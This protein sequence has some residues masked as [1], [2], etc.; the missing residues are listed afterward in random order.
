MKYPNK[1]YKYHGV[2]NHN[3]YCNVFANN[4]STLKRLASEHANAICYRVIDEMDVY[5]MKSSEKLCSMTRI[6]KKFPNN[7][8]IR[9][10]W[11]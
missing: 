8:M 3:V 7:T 9:G 4:F 11:K 5:D 2:V 10:Q 6:N 1:L